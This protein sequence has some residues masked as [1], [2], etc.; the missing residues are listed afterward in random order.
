MDSTSLIALCVIAGL[1]LLA[2]SAW[3]WN[4]RKDDDEPPSIDRMGW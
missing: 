2:L 4:R 1:L 3:L